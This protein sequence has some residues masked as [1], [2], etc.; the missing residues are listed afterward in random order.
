MP[1]KSA[2]AK[3]R[4]PLPPLPQTER[5]RTIAM[6]A[7][8]PFPT[9]QGTQVL[10]RQL[11]EGLSR[12]G[13]DV[14]LITYGYGEY[15]A[16]FPFTVHRTARIDAGLRSGPSL[17]RPA[18]DAALMMLAGKVIRTY[19]CEILH[20]HNVEGL[21]LGALL[22]LQTGLPLVYHAHNAM[23]PELPTYFKA[24]MAQAFAAL[25]GD[26][27]DRTLPRVADGVIAFDSDHKSLHEMYG[28]NE[29]R[30]HVIPPGLDPGELQNAEPKQLAELRLRLG[31]GPW[32]LYAGNP[33]NYQN[34]PLLWRAF[35]RVRRQRPDVKLLIATNYDPR[36]F[37]ASLREGP[38]REHIFIERFD[39]IEKLRALYA[40]CDIGVCP[41]SLWSGAPIKLLNYLA[42]GL[43]AVACRGSARHILTPGSGR[44]VDETPEAF[45]HGLLE[46]LENPPERQ[47]VQRAFA[48]FHIDAHIPLYEEVYTRIGRPLP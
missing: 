48:R 37:D 39:T 40:L 35:A 38:G 33:D 22:K 17:M 24:H 12:R 46:L 1:N 23:G 27:V 25:I 9:R 19:R 31:P 2:A 43:P 5:P 7:P 28:I 10:I 14:H 20:V 8:C 42:T 30:I 36:A 34:L 26:V 29:N 6:L 15:E 3:I 32:L 21:G 41:R 16:T 45:A 4:S 11:A 44:L 18:A 47:T 13:H